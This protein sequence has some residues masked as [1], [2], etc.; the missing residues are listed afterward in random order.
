LHNISRFLPGELVIPIPKLTLKDFVFWHSPNSKRA[1]YDF[2][3]LI[4]S[5]VSNYFALSGLGARF[6]SKESIQ[7]SS[8]E[9][10][11]TRKQKPQM[12]E[13]INFPRVAGR[14]KTGGADGR[15]LRQDFS[16]LIF[17]L[18]FGSSQKVSEKE[19]KP[20]IKVARA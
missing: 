20:P 15:R 5:T 13:L 4:L 16:D 1:G 11:F 12:V 10:F 14:Q 18:L 9:H 6:F 17:L 19:L 2:S 7:S 3:I 8:I